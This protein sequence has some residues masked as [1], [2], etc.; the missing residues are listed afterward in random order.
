[1]WIIQ[2]QMVGAIIWV[3]MGRIST[4]NNSNMK[5]KW[6]EAGLGVPLFSV[7]RGSVLSLPNPIYPIQYE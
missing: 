2:L 3:D 6:W 7:L 4:T 1:M 5:G